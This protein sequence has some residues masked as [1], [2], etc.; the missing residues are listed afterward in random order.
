MRLWP[1]VAPTNNFLNLLP[2]WCRLRD[3]S[4]PFA[5]ALKAEIEA[6]GNKHPVLREIARKL[7]DKAKEGDLQAVKE[8]ADRLDGKPA[9]EVQNT[10][11]TTTY[12]VRIPEPARCTEEW[13]ERYRPKP[14]QSVN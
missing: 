8:V 4:K 5:D 2:F 12:V 14:T 10:G 11:D 1:S 13:L 9:Q 3:S 6:A 7:L